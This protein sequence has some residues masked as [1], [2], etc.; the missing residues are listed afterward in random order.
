MERQV[1]RIET[2]TILT[3]NGKEIEHKSS[4]VY[5]FIS[6]D[7]LNNY[8]QWI[9]A[10]FRTFKEAYKAIELHKLSPYFYISKSIFGKLRITYVDEFRN[11]LHTNEKQFNKLQQKLCC[12]QYEGTM[13]D[14]FEKLSADEFIEY[15]LDKGITIKEQWLE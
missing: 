8:K 15:C 2:I 10:E 5:R 9:N 12:S 4:P 11:L 7:Q 6:E 13:K 3:R 14:Y 1:Y